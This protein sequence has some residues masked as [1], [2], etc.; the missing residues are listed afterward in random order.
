MG[1]LDIMQIFGRAGR[2]QFDK[3]GEGIIITEH[4][5]LYKY[6]AL[7][8]NQLPIE[9][10]FIQVLFYAC[11][12]HTYIHIHTYIHTHIRTYTHTHIYC[13]YNN[14][15]CCSFSVNKKHI[16]LQNTH[17][18]THTHIHTHARTH[19]HTCNTQHTHTHYTTGPSRSSQR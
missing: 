7:F 1:M 19:T 8:N 4:A 9:S 13:V 5:Q 3:S 18:H 14:S 12:L 2:P 11:I 16:I 10:Q 15:M 17:T 6:L